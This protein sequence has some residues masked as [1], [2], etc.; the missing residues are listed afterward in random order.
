MKRVNVYIS[1]SP[2]SIRKSKKRYGYVMECIIDDYP[3]TRDGFGECE[4]TYNGAVL[5]T[6]NEALQRMKWPCEIHIYTENTFVLDMMKNNL[7]LWARNGFVTS[8]GEPLKNQEEWMKLWQQPMKHYL[9]AEPG[10]HQFAEWIN[11]ILTSDK[12]FEKR[13]KEN[14]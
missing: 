1:I 13:G 10:R 14:V 3:E 6:I 5:R 7:A 9:V 2:A 8:K 11:G 4:E 12:E